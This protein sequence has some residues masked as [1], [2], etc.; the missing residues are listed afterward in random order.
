MREIT[1]HEEMLFQHRPRCTATLLTLAAA[2]TG[3]TQDTLRALALPEWEELL[4]TVRSALFGP[5]IEA[6]LTCPD[7]GAGVSLIFSAGDLP[8]SPPELPEGIVSLTAG[9]IADLEASG[10]MG[11]AAFAF[12][13]TRA[14]GDGPDHIGAQFT[15]ES[16]AMPALLERATFGLGS[17]Q[18][19][20]GHAL[21][22][23]ASGLA[24][25]LATAC[26]D[27]G[28]A[29]LAPFDIAAFFGAE[30][31]ARARR[32]LDEVHLIAGRYH[33]AEAE[34]LSLPFSRRQAYIARLL[35]EPLAPSR[36]ASAWA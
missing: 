12:L 21:E 3:R 8:R 2:L 25:E 28:A 31:E 20:F 14:L 19:A 15:G 5:R 6:E 26:T 23:A 11:E 29:M 17:E 1:G 36:A 22:L 34:I 35:T 13:Q 4:I 27:C 7:C 30:M 18:E 16:K 32:L 9:G 24:L 33:W 10:A